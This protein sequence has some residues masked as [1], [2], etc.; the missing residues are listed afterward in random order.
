[1]NKLCQGAEAALSSYIDLV[2]KAGGKLNQREKR[3][4]IF[5]T[6]LIISL[7]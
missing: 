3:S 4:E 2:R 5:S 1:M 7:V 6:K